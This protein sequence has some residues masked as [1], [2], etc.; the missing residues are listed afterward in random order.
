MTPLTCNWII[1]SPDVPLSG[2]TWAQYCPQFTMDA[3]V[4]T[5]VPVVPLRVA[6]IKDCFHI[7]ALVH[8]ELVQLGGVV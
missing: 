3:V 1:A 5:P 4:L 8:V 6:S 2:C 7:T